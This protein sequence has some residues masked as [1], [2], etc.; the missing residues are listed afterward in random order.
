VYP[1]ERGFR[2]FVLVIGKIALMNA[3]SCRFALVKNFFP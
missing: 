2:N 1:E 3:C